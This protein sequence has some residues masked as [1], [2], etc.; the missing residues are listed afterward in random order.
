[1]KTMDFL[2]Q[3]LSYI[4]DIE[5]ISN[6]ARAVWNALI[7]DDTLYGK[8]VYTGKVG[9]KLGISKYKVKNALKEIAKVILRNF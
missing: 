5:K 8:R 4:F 7:E 6:T 1:Y 9:K 3:D 2:R